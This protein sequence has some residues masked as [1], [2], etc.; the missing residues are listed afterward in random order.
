MST[1]NTIEDLQFAEMYLDY[2]A[3][4]SM[5]REE[6]AKAALLLGIVML[7]DVRYPG[8]RQVLIADLEDSGTTKPI[9]DLFKLPEPD[10]DSV[11]TDFI[12]SLTKSND[13]D[14]TDEK[15]QA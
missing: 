12:K 10:K 11:F 2:V 4:R 15:D 14:D 3:R 8:W 6:R 5:S 1:K 7:M 9:Q 13:N